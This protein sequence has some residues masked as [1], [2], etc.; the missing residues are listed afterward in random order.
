MKIQKN[1]TS[2]NTRITALADVIQKARIVLSSENEHL[3]L[4]P[5]ETRKIILICLMFFRVKSNIFTYESVSL[6]NVL[7]AL[8]IDG[9]NIFDLNI[10]DNF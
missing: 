5:E 10:N 4:R 8:N 2:T 6:K 7:T 1:M 9:I 3:D